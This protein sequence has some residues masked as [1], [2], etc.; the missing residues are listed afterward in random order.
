MRGLGSW[1]FAS[2]TF[3]A[4][5]RPAACSS[6]AFGAGPRGAAA[7]GRDGGSAASSG[8]GLSG[9]AGGGERSSLTI[10]SVGEVSGSLSRVSTGL[11]AAGSA[12]ASACSPVSPRA[13]RCASS[14]ALSAFLRAS[15]R[16]LMR[17][18]RSTDRTAGT[19]RRLELAGIRLGK[20]VFAWELRAQALEVPVDARIANHGGSQENHQFGF[21]AE[22]AAIGQRLAEQR[23]VADPGDERLGV[24]HDVLHQPGEHADLPALQAQDG[25]EFA[26]LEQ[27]D[28]VLGESLPG[29]RIRAASAGVGSS[30][31]PT[32]LR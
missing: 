27:R 21:P 31:D 23:D 22:I 2:N 15:S 32:F 30:T 20:E 6:P 19:E 7:L 5:A 17:C 26:R 28:L 1:N 10:S 14:F 18:A 24:L 4:L 3:F 12:A 13:R 8:A 29:N 25:I 16:R 9:A 11:R